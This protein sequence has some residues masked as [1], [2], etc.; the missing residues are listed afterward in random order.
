MVA[1][2]YVYID[3]K[4]VEYSVA[5]AFKR[6]ASAF[7]R[8]TGCTLHIASGTRTSAEQI[9]IFLERYVTAGNV[10]GR[11]VYDTRVWNG[12]RYY[13][14]SS[15]GTVAVPKT[16]NHEEAGPNGPRSIDIY[17]SGSSAGVTTRGSSRDKWME[18]NA[19][20]YG[21]ENEGYNFKEPWHK[22][23]RGTIGGKPTPTPTPTPEPTPAPGDNPT[24]EDLMALNSAVIS[25]L[26]VGRSDVYDGTIIDFET[27]FDT[28]W[29]QVAVSY[30]TT[31]GRVF[32]EGGAVIVTRSHYEKLKKEFTAFVADR[33]AHEL[34]IARLQGAGK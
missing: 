18:R 4:R 30:N 7:Y 25:A 11:Y 6:M 32:T 3:G 1:Y 19:D 17:D 31:M 24:L 14:I 28:D 26:S 16:S 2:T 33:K 22:T 20:T 27:G 21:F 15:A 12:T 34:E 13:R 5:E 8:D 10:R 23:F 9:A 29:G